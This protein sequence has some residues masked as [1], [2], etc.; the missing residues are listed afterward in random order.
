M[1]VKNWIIYIITII[2]LTVFCILYIKQSGFVVLM[3]AVFVPILFSAAVY[4]PGKRGIKLVFPQ[5]VVAAEKYKK[6]EIPIQIENHSPLNAGSAVVVYFVEK[7]GFGS[8]SKKMKRKLY[9][10]SQCTEEMRFE[11][12]STYSGIHEIWI[13]KIRKIGRA[14]V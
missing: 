13:E 11:F 3:I 14:H 6:I 4:I 9:L 7:R 12:V 8:G 2:S 10:G 5:E 1:A